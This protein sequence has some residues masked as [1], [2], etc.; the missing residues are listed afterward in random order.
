MVN[1]HR[2]RLAKLFFKVLNPVMTAIL[3]SPLHGLLSERLMLITINGRVSGKPYTI[4]VGYEREGDTLTVPTV[5][6]W[7]KNVR[8]GQPV[9][10]LVKGKT[11]RGTATPTQDVEMRIKWLEGSIARYGV[12]NARRFGWIPKDKEPTPEALAEAVQGTTLVHVKL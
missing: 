8:G 4:P 9:T 3:R 2:S 11:L 6:D 7:W 1:A 5:H 12:E 10:V